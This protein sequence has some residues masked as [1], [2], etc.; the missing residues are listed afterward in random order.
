MKAEEIIDIFNSAMEAHGAHYRMQVDCTFKERVNPNKALACVA[1][2][3]LYED[4]DD[5]FDEAVRALEIFFNP[6]GVGFDIVNTGD[7]RL[8]GSGWLNNARKPL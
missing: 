1:S 4:D 7:G 2:A 5:C 8:L 6:H 3:A